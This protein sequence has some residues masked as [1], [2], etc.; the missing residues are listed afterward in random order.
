MNIKTVLMLVAWLSLMGCSSALEDGVYPVIEPDETPKGEIVE[1]ARV[2][3]T[4][5]TTPENVHIIGQPL[6]R[7]QNVSH[8]DFTFKENEYTR[9]TMENSDELREYT[10][11]HVGSLV[12]VVIDGRVITSHKIREAIETDEFQ[13]TFCIEGA[14]DHLH[15]HLKEVKF[16]AGT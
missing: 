11:T 15:E 6:V 2:P 9:I 13:I 12:A 1:L 8:L 3:V 14:G 10:Q 7:F 4:S 16:A 5:D